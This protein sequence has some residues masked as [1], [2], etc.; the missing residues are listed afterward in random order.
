MVKA[1]IL[2]VLAVLIVVCAPLGSLPAVAATPVRPLG[3][4]APESGALLGTYTKSREG[5]YDRAGQEARWAEVEDAAGR[6]LDIGHSFYPW[7]QRFPS[8]REQWHLDSGRIPMI[9]WN[10]TSTAEIN[11][12]LHDGLIAE[13]ADGVKALGDEVFLRWFWEM[14]GVKKARMAGD[15]AEFIAAWRRM[16]DIFAQRG[17]GNAVWVWCPNAWAF[18]VDDAEQWYPGDDYVD[19]VCADGYNWPPGRP[20]AVW[21]SVTDIFSGFHAWGMARGKPMMVGETGVQERA[22]GEKAA[23]LRSAAGLLRD[24]LPGISAF[25]YFDSDTAHQWWLDSTPESRAAFR[26]MAQ[27]PYL[28]PD[29]ASGAPAPATS[30][31]V[32]TPDVGTPD[33]PAPSDAGAPDAGTPDAGAPAPAPASPDGTLG[34]DGAPDG[35]VRLAGAD[36]FA[37]ANR[38]SLESFPTDGTADAV[39]LARADRFADAL[40]SAGMAVRADA[41]VLLTD[42]AAVP[43][44]VLAEIQRALGASGTVYLLGGEAAIAAES[45]TALEALGYLVVRLAGEDRIATA[46]RI[47]TAMTE[48]AAVEHVVLA[49]AGNFPDA[50]AGAAY[51]AGQSAPVLLTPPD[52]LDPRV[53]DFLTGL[54][55]GVEVLVAGGTRA[56]S[57]AVVADLVARGLPVTRLAGTDRFST[58]AA[59]AAARFDDATAVVVATGA[60]FPDALAGAAHA[61]RLGA[62]VLLVGDTLPPPVRDYLTAR[63]GQITTV[64]VLGGEAAVSDGVVAEVEAALAA[65]AV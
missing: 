61:G 24:T 18:Q 26:T 65:P 36:R 3:R 50:L 32:G 39:L 21:R 28:N 11:A 9:S 63:A 22:P 6:R 2:R 44:S 4:L 62:P 51:A 19:W 54:G 52:A 37:T 14:D 20:D 46:L 55:T 30:P 5:G 56:V 25:V 64:H 60:N 31:D 58:A 13:R 35:A 38:V 17:A 12:G 34:T 43:L 7:E 29:G 53:A 41:P 49:S 59:I 8:W 45:A 15:P 33:A 23:W 47:A 1:H 27:D 10:G 57:D 42:T 16:H 48:G 40:A